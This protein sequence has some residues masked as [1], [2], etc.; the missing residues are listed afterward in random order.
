MLSPSQQIQVLIAKKYWSQG[1]GRE[2][3]ELLMRVAFDG[4]KAASVVAIVD[5]NNKAS[6]SLIKG[7]GFAH[8]STKQSDRWDNG[9]YVFECKA[10]VL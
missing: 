3:T 2:V 6:L 1:I 8:V 5:P 9:H 7:L 10:G 4:L